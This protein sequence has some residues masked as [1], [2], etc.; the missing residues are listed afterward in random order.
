MSKITL[1]NKGQSRRSFRI[2]PEVKK[3]QKMRVR[4]GVM[5]VVPGCDPQSG[6]PGYSEP[7]DEALLQA[8]AVEPWFVELVENNVLSFEKVA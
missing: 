8:V 2:R 6:K 1:V 5:I 4:D 7:I 3:G